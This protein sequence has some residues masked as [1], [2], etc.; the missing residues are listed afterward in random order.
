VHK[1][2]SAIVAVVLWGACA[3]VA[4][5][6]E[7]SFDYS[8]PLVMASGTLS[9]TALGNGS[10]EITSGEMYVTDGLA[11]G[12][13]SLRVNPNGQA[14][15][16]SPSGYFIYDNLLAPESTDG[17]VTWYG[18]LFA[19]AGAEINIFREDAAGPYTFYSHGSSGNVVDYGAFSAGWAV[20]GALP[21]VPAPGGAALLCVGAVVLGRRRRA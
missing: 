4:S 16:Y 15:A 6:D 12:V 19:G 17:V 3:G 9:G 1:D 21:D 14:P 18:L 10:F 13:Y 5:A 2:C 20:P 7:F 8:G 11:A